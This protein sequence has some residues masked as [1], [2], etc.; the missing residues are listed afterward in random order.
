[1]LCTLY[2]SFVY[3]TGMINVHSVT[4]GDY[5]NDNRETKTFGAAVTNG[6]FFFF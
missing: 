4:L 6:A 5:F 1:M 2:P 3:V